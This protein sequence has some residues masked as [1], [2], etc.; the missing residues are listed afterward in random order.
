MGR[1]TEPKP[2]EPGERNP[3]VLEELENYVKDYILEDGDDDPVLTQ[4]IYLVLLSRNTGVDIF[5]STVG[6]LDRPAFFTQCLQRWID[7]GVNEAQKIHEVA[8][9]AKA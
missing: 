4:Y 1:G 7:E 3:G 9:G 2:S 8:K 6:L 5:P